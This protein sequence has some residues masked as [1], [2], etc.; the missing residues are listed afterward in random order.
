MNGPEQVPVPDEEP[1]GTTEL[2]GP[3][4]YAPDIESVPGDLGHQPAGRGQAEQES[5]G[6]PDDLLSTMEFRVKLRLAWH[7]RSS[8]WQIGEKH[9][10]D[11]IW[12]RAGAPLW[13]AMTSAPT[14]VLIC[15]VHGDGS[16]ATS[17][18]AAIG[19]VTAGIMDLIRAGR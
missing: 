11:A 3:R 18:V 13:C 19:L 17:W 4:G 12:C 15:A 2:P 8:R 5:H 9:R 16:T 7:P 14:V 6:R 10:C 1:P